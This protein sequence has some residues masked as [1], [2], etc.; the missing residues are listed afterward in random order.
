VQG[1]DYFAQIFMAPGK[2]GPYV[3]AASPPSPFLT[4]TDAGY[5]WPRE[6]TAPGFTAGQQIWLLIRVYS[7]QFCNFDRPCSIFR[8]QSKPF[9]VVLRETPTPLTGL[10]PFSLGPQWFDIRRQSDGIVISWI[11]Q[12]NVTYS[13]ETTTDLADAESWTEV[14]RGSG[15]F[16]TGEVMSVTNAIDG[17]RR[18]FRLRK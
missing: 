6:V 2:E 14:W 10:E 1:S 9:P 4:G 12:G 7:T 11:N 17:E 8:G 13:L 15:D 18:F 3:S 16:P 5:W